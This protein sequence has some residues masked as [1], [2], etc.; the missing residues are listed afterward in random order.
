MVDHLDTIPGSASFSTRADGDID[1][2]LTVAVFAVSEADLAAHPNAAPPAAT[3]VA[4][5][6][7][8]VVRLGVRESA[9]V[10][11]D[12]TTHTHAASVPAPITQQIRQRLD[13]ELA[14]LEGMVL[15][16]GAPIVAA[17]GSSVPAEPDLGRGGGVVALRFGSTGATV[18]RLGSNQRWGVFLDAEEA[19]ALLRRR[20]PPGAPVTVRWQPDGTTPKIVADLFVDLTFPI[21]VG[22]FQTEIDL[23]NVI[24]A[25]DATPQ[26]IAPSTLRL[27]VSWGID[28]T[29]IAD[30]FESEVR[31]RVRGEIRRIFAQ[32]THDSSNSFYF[33]IALPG[34]PALLGTQPQWGGIT[35]STAGMTIGG[36]V[37]PAPDAPREVLDL[38]FHRFGRPVW[39]GRCRALAS[40]GSGNP[41]RHFDRSNPHLRVQAGASFTDAGALCEAR[42]QPPNEWLE[43][44]M[45]SNQNGVGFDLTI[46][47]AQE[48]TN[49]VRILVQTSRGAR[50]LDLG[51]PVIRPDEG[52]TGLDVQ[53]NYID[54][55]LYLS[56]PW[57]KLALGQALTV[58]DLRPIPLED[59]DWIKSFSA[60]RGLNSHI[61][62]IGGL[63][64]REVV[65]LRG[66]GIQ[67]Q[68]T[69]N[70]RGYAYVPA[71][72]PIG[73]EI[74][75]AIVERSSLRPFAGSVE[76]QSVEFTW[77]GNVGE[78]DAAAIRDVDGTAYVA[79]DIGD[80]VIVEKFQPDQ[81]DAFGRARGDEVSLNPQPLP[82]NPPEAARLAAAAGLEN[83]AAA[84]SWAGIGNGESMALATL[85]DGLTVIVSAEETGPRAIGEY[86]GP[87]VATQA[88]GD[89]AIAR[90]G[91]SVH[92]F[93]VQR[94]ANLVL[95][96]T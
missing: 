34:I 21:S 51:E 79:R 36:P 41:P 72:V 63:D 71:L 23:G 65:E 66:R 28:L 13:A 84:Y 3:E 45:N 44:H 33:D 78:A 20:V 85:R 86:S 69:A 52:G 82:P 24:G 17:L 42:L 1:A 7:R 29:G 26:F 11:V 5:Q 37:Q 61:V 64:P 31:R 19:V 22:P 94:P 35:A 75:E 25:V 93:A 16:D 53:V 38:S 8:V 14:A 91:G 56:G 2:G 6:V 74:Y 12:A 90:S 60:Q 15:L 27:V 32:A 68:V 77:L 76:V 30:I 87:L 62:T 89:Y 49:A 43:P 18:S 88:D 92:L 70:D 46:G 54:D 57:L 73:T 96:Q 83:V 58:D 55:C 48:V 81:P 95:E 47:V 4:G 40:G 50:L 59:P 9:L 10:I 67:L 39:W 80:E